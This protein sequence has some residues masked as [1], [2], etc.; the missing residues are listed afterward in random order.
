[1]IQELAVRT[2]KSISSTRSSVAGHLAPVAVTASV[3][4]LL[5]LVGCSASSSTGG[6]NPG[7]GGF[8]GAGSGGSGINTDGG[9]MDGANPGT[10]GSTGAAGSGLGGA[11]G[12]GGATGTGCYVTV[13]AVA[14]ATTVDVEAGKGAR[15]RVQGHVWGTFT[16][17]ITWEWAVTV[18]VGSSMK[19]VSTTVLDGPDAIVD[20][21]LED[22]GRYAVAAVA[23]SAGH[24]DCQTPTPLVISTVPVGPM[25]YAVRVTASGFPVQDMRITLDPS[26]P[27]PIAFPL[28]TGVAA[29]LVP[30]GL[31]TGGSLPSYIR[32]SDS[33]SGLS[34]DAD[35]TH[36]AVTAP[37]L[38]TRAYDVL[39]VPIDPIDTYA[40]MYL[41][42][43]THDSWPKPLQLDRGTL[44]NATMR[45]GQGN[46]V[47]GARLVLRHGLLPST[48]GVSDGSGAAPV[49]ARAG[50]LAAYV[51][52]PI[53]SG[54]PSASVGAG[55]DPSTDPGIVLDPGVDSLSLAMTWGP[56]TSSA[57]S[58]QV[59]APGGAAAGAGA[60]VRATSQ[61]AP[62][63]VGTLVASP[64]G[65]KTVTLQA[66]GFTDVEVVTNA[67]GIAAFPALPV[68]TYVV[69]VTPP[70]S[71]SASGL[72]TPAITSTSLTLAAGGPMRSVTLS[73]KSA[74]GGTLL[75]LSDSPGTQVTAIDQTVTAPGTVV[76]ATVDAN[77]MY[78]LFVDP[79]RNYEL[80]AQPPA[81]SLRGRAVLS[82]SVSAATAP[83][84][85]ATL[86]VAHLVPGTVTTETG[87]PVGGA[88]VQAF[89]PITSPK[90]LDATFPLAEAITRA[91]GTFQLTLPDPP[92]N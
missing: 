19:T 62:G 64:V 71:T 8:S 46:A 57:L 43:K 7:T 59:L 60:R 54:L 11:S 89:C 12:T 74:L 63:Q 17:P 48:V 2:S 18:T 41:L 9:A 20:F 21:P 28:H 86:P 26:N 32:I 40:P 79:G 10:G 44:V 5:G 23:Q 30:Q 22:V 67:T 92:A 75:P 66:T 80:R 69:T 42:N 52:P 88:L 76:S 38:D 84:A 53:G 29:N 70:S 72:S 56:V 78:K 90:C 4:A 15:M 27:Q 82:S 51:E 31:D 3:V 6:L 24:P 83:M 61:G 35:S 37:V 73:T 16:P 36:G 50:T 55:S 39:I 14:P 91:D 34:I 49:R 81:G 87:A 25:A 13:T 45:D 33:T 65:G 68:G 47:A 85:A 58:I 77:G 1:L